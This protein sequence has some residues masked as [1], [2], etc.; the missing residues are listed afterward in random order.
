VRPDRYR[1]FQV[2]DLVCTVK[3][4]ERKLEAR[5]GMTESE[6]S[7]FGGSRQ[8]KRNVLRQL[9]PKEMP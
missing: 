7:F 8:F 9:K 5:F 6:R 2:A 1:L 4:I 3:L